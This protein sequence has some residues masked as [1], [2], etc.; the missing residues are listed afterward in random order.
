MS[1]FGNCPRCGPDG[2]VVAEGKGRARCASCG[3]GFVSVEAAT[4]NFAQVGLTP[5]KIRTLVVDQGQRDRA[6]PT[7]DRLVSSFAVRREFFH[8]CLAC[9]AVWADQGAWQRAGV[10]SPRTD[11]VPFAALG[12]SS[13]GGREAPAGTWDTPGLP[14][15]HV[16]SGPSFMPS[17]AGFSERISSSGYAAILTV[18]VGLVIAGLIWLSYKSLVQS[19]EPVPVGGGYSVL[20]WSG[21]RK[22]EPVQVDSLPGARIVAAKGP[23]R[24][25]VVHGES[26]ALAAGTD[27]KRGAFANVAAISLYGKFVKYDDVIRHTNDGILYFDFIFFTEEGKGT[28]GTGRVYVKGGQW[29]VV[30]AV[31]EQKMFAQSSVAQSFVASLKKR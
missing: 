15:A 2:E 10:A 29:W 30:T 1:A 23:T 17:V 9:R 21:E 28:H 27:A 11:E 6:C 4:T 24:L 26:A 19:G 18:S 20:F 13:T 3:G 12:A 25:E 31:G 22:V 8:A 14:D 16:D 7:C 5:Q